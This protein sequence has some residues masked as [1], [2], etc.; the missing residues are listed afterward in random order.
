MALD[1]WFDGGT[2]PA[3]RG[4]V[5]AEALAAGM[6]RHRTADVVL[7]VHEL[8]AN[9]VRHGGG[10]GRAQLWVA[11]AALHCMVS[12]AGRGGDDGHAHAWSRVAVRP[13]LFQLGHGLWLVRGV[14]DQLTAAPGPGGS[15]VTAVFALP[16]PGAATE[17]R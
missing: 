2:L 7:A 10:S 6:P 9:A 1:Q 5:R 13:W 14:A 17:D 11:E 16:R 3:L 8:A 4:A 15:Q 12:D